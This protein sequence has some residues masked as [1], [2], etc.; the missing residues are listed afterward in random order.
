M[1]PNRE[2]ARKGYARLVKAM[3]ESKTKRKGDVE[4]IDKNVDKNVDKNCGLF[5]PQ[6]ITGF[7]LN[8]ISVE[9]MNI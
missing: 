1:Q 2:N 3:P 6:H 7:T 9:N 4:S 8:L 5:L